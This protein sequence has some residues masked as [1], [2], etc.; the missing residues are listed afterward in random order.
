MQV[1]RRVDYA[2]RALSYLAAQ[3]PERVIRKT[4]IEKMQDIPPHYLSKIMRD[5]V[6]S[7]FVTAHYGPKGG[8][9][10]AKAADVI[11]I[12][13]VYESIEGR[14]VLM[15]C[16]DHEGHLFCRYDSVC[17]QISVWERVQFLLANFL[18]G[19]SLRDVVDQLG[20][21]GRMGS[22]QN[23]PEPA[24]GRLSRR[25]RSS[26]PAQASPG[27]TKRVKKEFPGRRSDE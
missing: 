6:S 9:R 11:S 12:K 25:D 24:D 18:A 8:F 10:L 15:Q 5:L 22:G 17:P 1:G 14:L 7:G 21:R 13:D 27:G 3:P 2:I 23:G 16:L 20:L 19:I 26:V 4:E